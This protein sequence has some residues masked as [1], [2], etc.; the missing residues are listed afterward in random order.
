SEG[1]AHDAIAAYRDKLLAGDEA[2]FTAIRK[3]CE[4]QAEILE[5]GANDIEHTKLVIIGTMIVA[6]VE[7]AAAVATAWTGIGA[8]A[9]VAAR[10]A[11]QVAVRIAMKQLI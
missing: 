11:A 6:A 10:V 8:A 7:I 9:G 1:E 3:W 4:K 5:D 2:A